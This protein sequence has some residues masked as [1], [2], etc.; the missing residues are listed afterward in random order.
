MGNRTKKAEEYEVGLNDARRKCLSVVCEEQTKHL[1]VP[2]DQDGIPTLPLSVLT[3]IT[4]PCGGTCGDCKDAAAVLTGLEESGDT[5]NDAVRISLIPQWHL[6]PLPQQLEQHS[7]F[8]FDWQCVP[9]FT[10]P[11]VCNLLYV[12]LSPSLSNNQNE[13]LRDSKVKAR[14]ACKFIAE[15]VS[16]ICD[17]TTG[18]KVRRRPTRLKKSGLSDSQQRSQQ[19]QHTQQQHIDP[20]S[21]N[22]SKAADLRRN[23]ATRKKDESDGNCSKKYKMYSAK[24]PHQQLARERIQLLIAP[25]AA[26]ID[27]GME[28]GSSRTKTDKI[29][30]GQQVQQQSGCSDRKEKR[31]RG[32]P[33]KSKTS[34]F[35][36]QQKQLLQQQTQHLPPLLQLYPQHSPPPLQ[37]H[38][39]RPPPLLQQYPQHPPPLLQQHPQHPSPLPQQRTQF[40]L[41]SQLLQ[42]PQHPNPQPRQQP[43]FSSP[44]LYGKRHYNNSIQ[45]Q[46]NQHPLILQQQRTLPLLQQ[47]QVN[48]FPSRQPSFRHLQQAQHPLTSLQRQPQYPLPLQQQQ[49]LNSIFARQQQQLLHPLSV[50]HQQQQCYLQQ[51]RRQQ[52]Q[53]CH[54]QQQ[55]VKYHKA[56]TAT[57][58]AV[59]HCPPTVVSPTHRLSRL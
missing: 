2:A 24:Q 42:Q 11:R 36:L 51:Q 14:H 44:L 54:Y 7:S 25:I 41:P 49:L 29:T 3:S 45:Q 31:G 1:P 10:H 19:Q 16:K 30:Q 40:Q 28:S 37:Q 52:Q 57:T 13:S 39:Q 35:E 56:T 53:L 59:V 8:L 12:P 34:D 6:P 9:K 55:Q 23:H 33:K 38:P 58:T 47:Q 5:T 27:T 32:R 15:P 48:P 18:K 20:V 21:A 43:K 22:C 50:L 26:N 17:Y 4:C 46:Q